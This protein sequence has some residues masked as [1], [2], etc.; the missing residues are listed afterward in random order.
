[1]QLDVF[2]LWEFIV[3]SLSRD[4]ESGV[5]NRVPSAQTHWGSASTSSKCT[6]VDRYIM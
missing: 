1:M 3:H 5:S 2:A 4:T 6:W